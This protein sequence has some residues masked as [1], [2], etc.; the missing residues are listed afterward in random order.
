MFF[1]ALSD[2]EALRVMTFTTSFDKIPSY[3]GDCLK[4]A[5]S[6]LKYLRH[7]EVIQDYQEPYPELQETLDMINCRASL[8]CD[9]M[10]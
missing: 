1:Y 4:K 8:H 2:L 7:I 9:L 5:V 6:G 3:V 10:F